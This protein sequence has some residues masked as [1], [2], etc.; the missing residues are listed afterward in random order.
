M[1]HAD[2]IE[3]EADGEP[4]VEGQGDAAQSTPERR[5]FPATQVSPEN[6][7]SAWAL[8][9]QQG[10]QGQQRRTD[11]SQSDTLPYEPCDVVPCETP[12]TSKCYESVEAMDARIAFLQK[13]VRGIVSALGFLLFFSKLWGP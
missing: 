3:W 1:A 11:P 9:L 7:P 5:A 2:E 10:Q 6:G 13:L 4:E 12:R 8:F